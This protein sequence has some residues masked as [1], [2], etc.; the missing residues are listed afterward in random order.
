MLRQSFSK[1]RKRT[2]AQW[3]STRVNDNQTET[4]ENHQT[5]YGNESNIDENH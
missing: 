4:H 3:Q 5:T 1:K 2:H